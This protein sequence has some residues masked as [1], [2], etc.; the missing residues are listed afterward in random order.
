M[1]GKGD[2]DDLGSEDLGYMPPKL[3]HL[4]PL[5][6]QDDDPESRLDIFNYFCPLNFKK[7]KTSLHFS[8]KYAYFQILCVLTH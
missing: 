8:K 4:A 3:E 2:I 5:Q 1:Y 7:K 6:V